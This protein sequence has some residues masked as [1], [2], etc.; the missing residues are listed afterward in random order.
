MA[1]IYDS[2]EWPWRWN[3]FHRAPGCICQT[4]PYKLRLSVG[5]FCTFG[6]F[7][8]STSSLCFW[9]SGF[10]SNI[11]RHLRKYV[12][13]RKEILNNKMYTALF[14]K[15]GKLFSIINRLVLY[16]ANLPASRNCCSAARSTDFLFAASVHLRH[17]LP[18]LCYNVM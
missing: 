6:A 12:K 13:M 11:S 18:Q 5:L 9:L 17:Q 15:E 7:I 8:H 14:F 10:L 2:V 4:Q 16:E 3:E 1:R